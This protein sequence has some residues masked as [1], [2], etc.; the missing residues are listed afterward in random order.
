MRGSLEGEPLPV[1]REN[2]LGGASQFDQLESE[3][4]RTGRPTRPTK[5]ER[6]VTQMRTIARVLAKL[7]VPRGNVTSTASGPGETINGVVVKSIIAAFTA[8]LDEKGLVD[9]VPNGFGAQT[10]RRLIEKHVDFAPPGLRYTAKCT[11][12]KKQ[13]PVIHGGRVAT[14]EEDFDALI[15]ELKSAETR[16]Y[17]ARDFAAKVVECDHA[18]WRGHVKQELVATLREVVNS[19]QTFTS[20]VAVGAAAGGAPRPPGTRTGPVATK[21]SN[22]ILAEAEAGFEADAIKLKHAGKL[23]DEDYPEYMTMRFCLDNETNKIIRTRA[24]RLAEAR[25]WF[26][27][28]DLIE[29][30]PLIGDQDTRMDDA[31]PEEDADVVR[32]DPSPNADARDASDDAANAVENDDDLLLTKDQRDTLRSTRMPCT[33][34]DLNIA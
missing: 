20:Y 2:A 23:T 3:F 18:R 27:V 8:L 29:A 32:I 10:F 31:W 6:E 13:C 4:P 14:T 30:L 12:E 21:D 5:K 25:D 15:E 34:I 1:A 24:R 33:Q 26:P 22:T 28:D 19:L 9:A 7:Y 16:P 17:L 11:V